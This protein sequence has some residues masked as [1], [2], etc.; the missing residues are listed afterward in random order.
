MRRYVIAVTASWIVVQ[1]VSFSVVSAEPSSPEAAVR[2]NVLASFSHAGPTGCLTTSVFVSADTARGTIPS[3][4]PYSRY[5]PGAQVA[6]TRND[7]CTDRVLTSAAGS[8]AFAD[9]DEAKALRV[10]DDLMRAVLRTTIPA[11]D[12]VTGSSLEVV[13]DLTWKGGDPL[14]RTDGSPGPP[15]DRGPTGGLYRESAASGRVMYLGTSVDLGPSI[16]ASVTATTYR[17][18]RARAGQIGSSEGTA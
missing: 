13:V 12:F 4:P 18:D 2:Q 14:V 17:M 11:T 7:S 16:M 6:I 3:D 5:A 9:G 15:G 8:V 1:L 10:D